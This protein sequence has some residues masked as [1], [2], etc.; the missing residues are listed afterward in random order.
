MEQLG[1]AG[2]Q[3]IGIERHRRQWRLAREGEQARG[4]GRRP[5]RPL[6]RIG[7]VAGN[8]LAI[9]GAALGHVEAA[10]HDAQHVVE[11]VRDAAAQLADRFHL[12]ELAELTLRGLARRHF[13]AQP[14]QRLAGVVARLLGG[15]EADPRVAQR[16][17]G[18]DEDEDQR[19]RLPRAEQR[20]HV[21][22][23]GGARG[24]QRLLLRPHP[25]EKSL[26]LIHEP[27]ALAAADGRDRY[28]RG[29]VR[30]AFGRAL[31][32]RDLAVDERLQ[33]VQ[34][35]PLDGIVRRE[36]ADRRE[37]RERGSARRRHACP[38]LRVAA[39]QIAAMRGFGGA[40]IALE[41]RDGDL[42]IERV[43][44]RAVRVRLAPVEVE[45]SEHREHDEDEPGKWQ[46]RQSPEAESAWHLRRFCDRLRSDASAKLASGLPK[47][48]PPSPPRR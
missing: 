9:V 46:E 41:P 1:H 26:D 3:P 34:R 38:Q 11:V 2:D 25:I 23:M 8:P 43:R 44:H 33:P 18:H 27:P 35:A 21:L 42:N 30:I 37:A 48:S 6:A 24:E 19:R 36:R 22:G 40:K 15:M 7:E 14:R 39:E 31:G 5:L 4:E 47:R 28:A 17:E 13:L 45:R 20:D 12:A 10:D 32:D 29:G 16:E